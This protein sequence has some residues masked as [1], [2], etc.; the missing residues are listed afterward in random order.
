MGQI[1]TRDLSACPDRCGGL[2]V[3]VRG[4]SLERGHTCGL[5]DWSPS[6]MVTLQSGLADWP[7]CVLIRVSVESSQIQAT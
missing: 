2:P 1:S 5:R 3:D 7:V 4:F 6:C